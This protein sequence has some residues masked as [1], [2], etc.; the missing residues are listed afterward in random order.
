MRVA[1]M[2]D[3]PDTRYQPGTVPVAG[4]RNVATRRGGT[5][6]ATKH[7]LESRRWS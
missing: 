1:D 4:T 6:W 5:Q 2:L 7:V 3:S